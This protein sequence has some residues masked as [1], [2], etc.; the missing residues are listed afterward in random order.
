MIDSNF[1]EVFEF[2]RD[3]LNLSD[4]VV[5]GQLNRVDRNTSEEFG[6]FSCSAPITDTYAPAT[7]TR[8]FAGRKTM[9]KLFRHFVV[10]G[11]R[12][13]LEGW[14]P[15]DHDKRDLWQYDETLSI[16]KA[17]YG[18]NVKDILLLD[19]S[20]EPLDPVVTYDKAGDVE[21]HEERED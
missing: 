19:E 1:R 7:R 18:D 8:F 17:A 12:W 2:C 11:G 21:N 13:P 10:S 16:L 5:D 15:D 6:V 14:G 3:N 9:S 4:F 20:G